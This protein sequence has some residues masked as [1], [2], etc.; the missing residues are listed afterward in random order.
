MV[1]FP[2]PLPP[3]SDRPRRLRVVAHARAATDELAVAVEA[4][5]ER[6]HRIDVRVSDA[7]GAAA[8]LAAEAARDGVET[9][10]AAG[11]DGTLNEV[12]NGLGR[13]APA[14]RPAL[15]VVPGGTA[16]D[17]AVAAGIPRGDPQAALELV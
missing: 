7:P 8:R 4:L 10:V 6:G 9:V 17:F 13:V 1:P 11:G 16:N 15:G 2:P 12:V 5:R 3:E 14:A